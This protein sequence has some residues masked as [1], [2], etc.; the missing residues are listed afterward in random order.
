MRPKANIKRKI[1]KK[2]IKMYQNKN[3]MQKIARE[4][5]LKV[6]WVMDCLKDN[7]IPIRKQR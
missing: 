5:D 3:S 1:R 7:D 2:I 4:L 6:V